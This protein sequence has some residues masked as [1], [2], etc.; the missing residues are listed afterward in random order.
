MSTLYWTYFTDSGFQKKEPS[1]ETSKADK[2]KEQ[3]K[4]AHSRKQERGKEKP[5]KKRKVTEKVNTRLISRTAYSPHVHLQSRHKY[6]G[7]I[8]LK[9]YPLQTSIPIIFIWKNGL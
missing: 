8:G 9:E 2:K 4:G 3:G 1:E 6:L 7:K 5:K